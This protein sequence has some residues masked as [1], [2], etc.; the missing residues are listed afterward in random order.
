ME[1][2]VWILVTVILMII[3][4]FV[5][6]VSLIHSTNTSALGYV[7]F[8]GTIVSIILAVLAIGYTYGESVINKN[9]SSNIQ[10][11]ITELNEAVK[12]I[13]DIVE[14]ND[15][16]NIKIEIDSSL[17]QLAST[18]KDIQGYAKNVDNE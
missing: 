3:E 6:Y 10:K 8:A 13:Q 2:L 4:A 1:K 9:N 15:L 11:Y 5:F 12:K 7:T 14:N 18:A 17:V 16:E